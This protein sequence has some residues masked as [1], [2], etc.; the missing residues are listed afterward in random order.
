MPTEE[1][2]KNLLGNTFKNIFFEEA[3]T[4]RFFKMESAK[5][6]KVKPEFSEEELLGPYPK[7]EGTLTTALKKFE[8]KHFLK[9]IGLNTV[10]KKRAKKL[11]MRLW[12]F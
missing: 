11:L 6:L 12:S 7:F 10:T 5:E 1:T 8:I 3:E 4:G 9:S 2:E